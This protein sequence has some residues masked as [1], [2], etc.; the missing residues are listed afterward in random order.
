MRNS[1]NSKGPSYRGRAAKEEQLRV[2]T[3]GYC[4]GERLDVWGLRKILVLPCIVN[5]GI[6]VIIIDKYLLIFV[7]DGMDRGPLPHVGLR[8]G[9][10]RLSAHIYEWL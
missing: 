2:E 5:S 7:G 1:I 6:A 10:K 9:G 8:N 3:E 4:M